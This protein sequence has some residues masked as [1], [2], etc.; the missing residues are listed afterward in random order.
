MSQ[1][2][3]VEMIIDYL[4]SRKSD[5]QEVIKA[6]AKVVRARYETESWDELKGAIAI[7]ADRLDKLEK[8]S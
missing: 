1:Q 8:K 7:L 2:S 4:E 5:E 6:A 3:K